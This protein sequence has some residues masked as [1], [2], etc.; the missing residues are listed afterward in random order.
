MEYIIDCQWIDSR[1]ELHR[2][3]AET[4]SF[5][6]WYGHNLDALHDMLIVIR[7]ETHL[8]FQNW[9]PSAPAVKG[10]KRVLEDVEAANPYFSVAYR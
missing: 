6:E 10:L 1:A 9:N 2:V 3:L 8:V 7:A 4:L 5:P